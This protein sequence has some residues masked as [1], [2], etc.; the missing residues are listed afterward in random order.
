MGSL[1]LHHPWV[2]FYLVLV[3]LLGMVFLWD[4][5][6]N[7]PARGDERDR[8]APGRHLRPRRWGDWA[9]QECDPNARRPA[10]RQSG[11]PP[12]PGPGRLPPRW[13][14]PPTR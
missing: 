3:G 13:R 2:Q 4:W 7:P 8:G 11:W 5:W 9:P 12:R 1:L 14:W 6:R 10:A